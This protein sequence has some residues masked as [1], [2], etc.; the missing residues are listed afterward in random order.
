MPVSTKLFLFQVETM[1]QTAHHQLILVTG[2]T[3]KQGGAVVR[4]LLRAGFPVRALTRT[5]NSPASKR[6]E[7]QGVEVVTGDLGDRISL[8]RPVSGV[9]GVFSVQNYWEK[10]VGFAG[11]IQ[12]GKNLADAAK[13]AGV[14]HY[15]QSSMATGKD[16]QSIEHFESKSVVEAYVAQIG[17]P[18]TI[19]GTVYFMENLLDPKMG[20]SMTFPTL[21]GSLGPEILFHLLTVDDLGGIV[22]AIF[23][24]RGR[25][26]G[27]KVDMASDRLT[28][29]QMKNI[30]QQNSGRHPKP[31]RIPTWLLKLLNREFAQQ[32][33]WHNK[34]GW[35]FELDSVRSIYPDLTNF[36]QFLRQH[37]ITNL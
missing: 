37:Q 7:R 31:W 15:V 9:Y 28:I 3:G 21:S 12:Q 30:Y 17:L 26:L 27:Q 10:G 6:L 4:H 23:Q 11:E 16:F 5:A 18:Y 24:D 32:L 25:F 8:D 19:V 13:E 1:N 29:A 36:Q 2:A 22:A 34:P 14:R 20:G 35:T 33:Q